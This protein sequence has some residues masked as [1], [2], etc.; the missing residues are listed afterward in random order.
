VKGLRLEA[1]TSLELLDVRDYVDALLKRR[2]GKERREIE[3]ALARISDST[4]DRPG[5]GRAAKSRGI[6]VPPKYR[7]P[8]T[9]E[10][11]SGRGTTPRWLRALTKAGH[12]LEDF[13]VGAK[14]AKRKVKSTKKRRATPR[15]KKPATG[16]ARR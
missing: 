13:A 12:K 7:D 2:I 3:A 5:R 8:K 11:W 10:S 4:E 14:S 16:K 1:L 6:K 9:G 15:R